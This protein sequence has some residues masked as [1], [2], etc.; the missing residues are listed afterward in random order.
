MASHHIDILI[1]GGGLVGSVLAVALKD[2]PL[3]IGLVETHPHQ[4]E[5]K[6]GLDGRSFALSASSICILEQ[7][8]I[9]QNL[10]SNACP[11][12]NIHVSE[13]YGWAQSRLDASDYQMSQF[14]AVIEHDFLMEHFYQILNDSPNIQL[15]TPATVKT[16]SS[17]DSHVE[18]VAQKKNENI[19]LNARVLVAADGANSIVRKALNIP[20]ETHQYHQQALVCNIK[21]NRHH[22]NTAYERFMGKEM[23]A[24]LPLTESRQALVWAMDESRCHERKNLSKLDFL[25][26]LQ[27]TFGY[28]LGRFVDVGERKSFPLAMSYLTNT[29]FSRAVFL[30]N[31]AH[32]LHPI[33]GQGF[34]LGLRDVAFLAELL[35][36][37]PQQPEKYLPML[38]TLREADQANTR[39]FTHGLINVFSKYNQKASILRSLGLFLFDNFSP[40]KSELVQFAAGFSSKNSRLASSL[41]A[42]Q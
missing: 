34:N 32:T 41:P 21:L 14:G 13:R 26:A 2:S 27:H 5:I 25:S 15:I 37:D 1:V 31:A 8:G 4:P 40:A 20:I 3:S 30:G 24:L 22:K 17:F 23:M 7:L 33:A 29:V 28:R 9:W 6:Q 10:S 11:I 18:V 19:T 38:Q 42:S 39:H 16:L 12:K 35:L 36:K